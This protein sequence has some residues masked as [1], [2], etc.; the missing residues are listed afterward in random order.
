[1]R[2]F[3]LLETKG[4]AVSRPRSGYFVCPSAPKFLS[5][6]ATTSPQ[7]SSSDSSIDVL[8]GKVYDSSFKGLSFSLGVPDNALL[9]VAKLNKSLVRA[10]RRMEGCGVAMEP[11]QGNV[12]LR[13]QVARWAFGMGARL[14]PDNI[15]TSFG[16]LN[17]ISFCLMALTKPGDRIALESPVSFGMLQVA[18]SLGL[19]VEEMPCHPVTG[20]DV[21]ALEKAFKKRKIRV[22]LLISNFSNP[23]G[24]CMPDAHKQ[25]VVELVQRSGI[26]L[27]ENDINGDIYFGSKRPSSC[28]TFDDSGLVLWCGSVSKTLA[29]GYRVGWV[30]AGRFKDQVLRVKR[31]HAISATSVTHEAIADFLEASRYEA[32]LRKLRQA[33]YGNYLNYLRSIESFFPAEGLRVSRPQGGSVLW[34]ELQRKVDTVA[35]YEEVAARQ[36][37]I[38]PG[39]IFTLK[40]QYNNCMRLNYGVEWDERRR[41]ALRVLGRVI[42]KLF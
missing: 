36:I 21:D 19:E 40:D 26:P 28:K 34:V 38:A 18:R 32:H 5:L 15:I 20:V 39:R 16:C 3:H 35:L 41:D 12:R 37:S 2:S 25:R 10:M 6:P 24:G 7:A 42:G 33:L 27:I 14:D 23:L 1:M 30:E 11:P 4:L 13:R 31:Y 9:P 22:C 29:P 17:A 8:V